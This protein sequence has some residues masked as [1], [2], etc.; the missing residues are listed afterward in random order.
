MSKQRLVHI[1]ER[2]V[3]YNQK[4]VVA[5]CGNE[6]PVRNTVWLPLFPATPAT[7]VG[8]RAIIRERERE[9]S[10]EAK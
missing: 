6:V 3:W 5:V 1:R 8:C 7:C 4:T 10:R 9:A 2:E